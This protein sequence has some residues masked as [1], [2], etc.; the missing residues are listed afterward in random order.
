M[1][2]VHCKLETNSHFSKDDVILAS[3]DRT[4]RVGVLE[5]G[6]AH[7]TYFDE[8]GNETMTE[9]LQPGDSFGGFFT[10][11][12]DGTDYEVVAGGECSVMFINVQKSIVGC[13]DECGQHTELL[14][15]LLLISAKHARN[16]SAHINIL[17][18][19][20]LRDKIMAYLTYQKVM[21]SDIEDSFE[22]PI[23]LANLANY[24]AVDRSSM[25]R[26]LRKMNDE[27]LIESKGRHFKV[28]SWI[29]EL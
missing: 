25:M 4:G 29:Q 6:E 18:Q 21:L 20:T 24:L 23:S 13:N 22:I 12:S 26:E 17:S 3:S 7:V 1:S 5:T 10:M 9:Y 15:K 28:L 19:R 2:D 11:L 14:K 8:S 16:Q 27:G